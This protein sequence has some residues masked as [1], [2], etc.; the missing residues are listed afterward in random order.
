MIAE[1]ADSSLGAAYLAIDALTGT[2]GAWDADGP[3]QTGR[4][5]VA[6]IGENGRILTEMLAEYVSVISAARSRD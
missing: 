5:T 6:P 1:H 4:R 3:S 2:T